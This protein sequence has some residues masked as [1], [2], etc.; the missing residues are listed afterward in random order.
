[1]EQP[2]YV[3]VNRALWNQRTAI[4]LQSEFYG[5]KGFLAGQSSLNPVELGLLG[6]V[7][8]QS[9]LHLQC[10]FGQDTLSLARLG[11][12]VTGVDLADQAIDKARELSRQLDL[13]AEFICCNLY[14][15]P[16]HLDKRYDIVFASYGVVGWLPDLQAW[17][18]VIATF[19]KPGGRFVLVEFHPVVWMFDDDFTGIQYPYFNREPIVEATEGTYADPTAPIRQECITWNHGLSEVFKGLLD[20]GLA[21]SHFDEYD[22]SPYNCFRHTE[23]VGDRKY[24]IK[25]MG[26]KLPMLYSVVAE[27]R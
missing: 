1:M 18:K 25:M 3:Q 8:G 4:H 19:L 22:Y 6:E 11:A 15:L 17:G 10:H 2:R 16:Q 23:Q 24:R 20:N 7:A 5:L 21:I 14:D 27:Q 13:P 9:I 26:D 12:H